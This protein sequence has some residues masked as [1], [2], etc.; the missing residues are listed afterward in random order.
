MLLYLLQT[1]PQLGIGL[2]QPSDQI[3]AALARDTIVHL[4]I[5]IVADSGVGLFETS[6]IEWRLPYQQSIKYAAE[7]P[8]IRLVAVRLLVQ[9]F[10]SDVVRCAAYRPA[11]AN[12]ALLDLCLDEHIPSGA[13]QQSLEG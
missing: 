6:R 2:Q 3:L 11:N 4:T 5:M 12:D 9:H 7:R 8:N 10:R 1:R 13:P